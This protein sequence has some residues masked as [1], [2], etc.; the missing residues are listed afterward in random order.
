M[1]E[2]QH[3]CVVRSGASLESEVGELADHGDLCTTIWKNRDSSLRFNGI[4][5]QQDTEAA[6]RRYFR[7]G[8]GNMG[9]TPEA[10]QLPSGELT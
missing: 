4:N 7:A 6:Q 9:K 5:S 8:D 2:C 3:A 1:V 10:Y